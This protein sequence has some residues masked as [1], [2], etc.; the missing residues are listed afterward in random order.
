MCDTNRSTCSTTRSEYGRRDPSRRVAGSLNVDQEEVLVAMMFDDFM[1]TGMQSLDYDRVV[2][3]AVT[4]QVDP[5]VCK[6]LNA[7]PST[8]EEC[9]MPDDAWITDMCFAFSSTEGQLT[10]RSYPN[11]DITPPA[12]TMLVER[13]SE[14]RTGIKSNKLIRPKIPAPPPQPPPSASSAG[15]SSSAGSSGGGPSQASSRSSRDRPG[16][17]S[18]RS[19]RERPAS[20]AGGAGDAGASGGGKAVARGDSPKKGRP[21]TKASPKSAAKEAASLLA[22]PRK[23]QPTGKSKVKPLKLS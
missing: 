10:A 8:L 6:V 11:H 15:A 19:A 7:T 1:S 22:D 23:P 2:R 4:I 18:S 14:K 9:W 13:G 3:C 21:K 5:D 16:S 17:S 20:A 12:M